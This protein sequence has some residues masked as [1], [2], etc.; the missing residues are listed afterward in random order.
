MP[1][2]SP[3][4]PAIADALFS[5]AVALASLHTSQGLS[6][7]DGEG[8]ERRCGDESMP[9]PC[10]WGPKGQMPLPRNTANAVRSEAVTRTRQHPEVEMHPLDR[11]RQALGCC[12]LLG[13]VV[14]AAYLMW[15]IPTAPWQPESPR[16]APAVP[17]SA[18]SQ[19]TEVAFPLVAVPQVQPTHRLQRIET[20]RPG[21]RML[22]RNPLREEVERGEEPEAATWRLIRLEMRKANSRQMRA[23]WL[24]PLPWLEKQ[25]GHVGGRVRLD[26]PEM[27]A[28][29]WATVIA[30]DP[31]PEI[32]PGPGSVVTGTFQHEP[33]DNLVDVRVEGLEA[34]I[35]CTD[36]HPFWS[37]DR[38]DFVPVGKLHP[39]ERVRAAALG[40]VAVVSITPHPRESWVYNLEVQ[41]EHVFQVS[42]AGV[43]VHNQC[44]GASGRQPIT[45]PSRLL[46]YKPRAGASGLPHDIHD[47][48]VAATKG[49]V[50]HAEWVARTTPQQRQQLIQFF[51]DRA[52]TVNVQN[53]PG[54]REFNLFRARWLETGQGPVPGNLDN[55]R[56]NILPTLPPG[57]GG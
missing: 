26:L 41:G 31:C 13:S 30:I 45:D 49:Q 54:A 5:N 3:V 28:V 16:V 21:Q 44:S 55:F 56:Q 24:R 53:A 14:L 33:D 48:G 52:A 57:F 32:E 10:G 2:V 37:E 29:G 25:Q 50:S 12:C 43:L 8:P 11:V 42:E 20:I 1:Q 38:S 34:P 4:A 18:H 6:Q 46:E 19:G 36:N 51:R 23:E 35:G 40:A 17:V 9:A 39:G 22:G 15:G 7:T 47:L 27:G